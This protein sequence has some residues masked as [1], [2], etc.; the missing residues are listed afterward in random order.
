M[1]C[2][3]NEKNIALGKQCLT[4][5][6]TELSFIDAQASCSANFGLVQPPLDAYQNI[7]LRQANYCKELEFYLLN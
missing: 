7:I 5:N 4:C 2:P 6:G 1:A 3:K